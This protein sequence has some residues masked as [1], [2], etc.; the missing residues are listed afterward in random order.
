MQRLIL[1][2]TVLLSL[3]VNVEAQDSDIQNGF[4]LDGGLAI[5]TEVVPVQN[6]TKM[7]L[8]Q[9]ALIWISKT[10]KS[11]KTVI[12]TKDADLGLVTLKSTIFIESS[13][14][15]EL[16]DDEWYTF[17]LSIQAK[18]GRYKY[19]FSDIVYTWDAS[20][21]DKPL[22]QNQTV[23]TDNKFQKAFLPIVS[24][25]KLQMSKKEEAW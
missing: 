5:I 12:Q 1:L 14:Y 6:K 18:D 15:Q 2:A 20:F 8:Y 22:V 16:H 25:I 9:D 19:V 23:L 13:G 10:F 24:S 7:E 11:P 21:M 4:K 17:N 3:V